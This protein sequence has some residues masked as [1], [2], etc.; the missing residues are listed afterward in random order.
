MDRDRFGDQL[1]PSTAKTS[2]R[3][4]AGKG[5]KVPPLY[6]A[7]RF[8]IRPAGLRCVGLGSG[9]R[10]ESTCGDVPIDC[11]VGLCFCFP[12]SAFLVVDCSKV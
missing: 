8:R 7:G 2:G 11:R 6:Y 1:G 9:W 5:G 10:G 12:E 3:I 4:I